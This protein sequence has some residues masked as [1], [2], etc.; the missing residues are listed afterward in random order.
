MD[1]PEI[2]Q[3]YIPLSECK[4]GALYRIFSRNLSLGVFNE[5]AQGFIGIREKF[6][7]YYLFTEYHW[8][9]GAPFGT[10]HPKELLEMVPDDIPST[11]DV[12]VE[13]T[14]EIL[15]RW[16]S[17]SYEVGQQVGIENEVLFKWLEEK[18]EQYIKE[19]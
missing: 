5:A 11:E 16:A 9:T 2:D 18:W 8:D 7:R 12:M 13:A 3:S 19:S 10:V 14:E 15:S 4:H 17:H 6:G 1:E